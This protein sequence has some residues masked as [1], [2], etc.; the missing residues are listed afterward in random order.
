[1]YDLAV[2]YEHPDWFRPLFAAL[3]RR[4]VDHVR[5]T[6]DLAWDPADSTSPGRLVLNRIAMSS[7][8][9]AGDGTG[10]EH[11]ILLRGRAVRPLGTC[12]RPRRQRRRRARHRRIE[13]TPAVTHRQPR[14]R[15]S[16]HP[17]RSPR[18]RRARC[19]AGDR[20]PAR[21]EKRTLAVRAQESVAST[22]WRSFATQLK[23]ASCRPASTA[24]CWSRT[25]SLR[26]AARL[27]G[28]KRSTA[29]CS[30]PS[31]WMAA[32]PSTF[33]PPTPV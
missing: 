5:L 20:L 3:Y 1:M 12:R 23:R 8:L 18:S 24:Y 21:R 31:R 7:F 15:R 11:P 6:P 28:W 14:P 27:R 17:R 22:T 13:S 25:M 29:A 2:I 16:R 9:R 10:D 19:R 30:T 4:G 26:A 33:A 32:V